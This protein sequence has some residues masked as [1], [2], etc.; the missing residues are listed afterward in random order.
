[1]PKSD[2][3]ESFKGGTEY[4]VIQ[5][6]SQTIPLP[7]RKPLNIPK[8]GNF[9]SLSFPFHLVSHQNKGKLLAKGYRKSWVVTTLYDKTFIEDI[10]LSLQ[11]FR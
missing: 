1:M 10:F 3:T 7:T 2:N 4:C 11:K 6:I 8:I 5:T 9:M